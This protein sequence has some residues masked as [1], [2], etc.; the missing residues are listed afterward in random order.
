MFLL[1]EDEQPASYT[2]P[3]EGGGHKEPRYVILL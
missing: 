3:P 2:F 1:A